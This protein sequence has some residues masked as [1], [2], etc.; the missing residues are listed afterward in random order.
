VRVAY[1]VRFNPWSK[2]RDFLRYRLTGYT[3]SGCR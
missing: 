2:A 1:S 3:N